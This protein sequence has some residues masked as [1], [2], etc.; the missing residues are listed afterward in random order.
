MYSY[1][2]ISYPIQAAERENDVVR[3]SPNSAGSKRSMRKRA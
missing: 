3:T 1:K 2:K